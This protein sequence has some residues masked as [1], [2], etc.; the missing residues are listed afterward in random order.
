MLSDRIGSAL[1]CVHRKA[2]HHELNFPASAR[3]VLI[4]IV[5]VK[6]STSGPTSCLLIVSPPP[7]SS[8]NVQSHEKVPAGHRAR[9]ETSTTSLALGAN[10]EGKK[11]VKGKT[12]RMLSRRLGSTL[13]CVRRNAEHRELKLSEST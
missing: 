8:Q 7:L 2:K 6:V 9:E 10:G 4:A 12:S 11:R 5:T 1:V 13:V 3:F